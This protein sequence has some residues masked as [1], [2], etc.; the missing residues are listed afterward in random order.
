M[1]DECVSDHHMVPQQVPISYAVRSLGLLEDPQVHVSQIHPVYFQL[2]ITIASIMYSVL[3]RTDQSSR[4]IPSLV[5]YL[6]SP[7]SCTLSHH[8]NIYYQLTEIFTTPPLSRYL[9]S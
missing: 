8:M 2:H 7:L 5:L 1:P 4:L 9:P 6:L 3:S